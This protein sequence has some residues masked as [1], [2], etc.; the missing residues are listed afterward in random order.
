MLPISLLQGCRE[1]ALQLWKLRAE[2]EQKK[3]RS[4]VCVV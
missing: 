2:V 3:L 1:G 4:C